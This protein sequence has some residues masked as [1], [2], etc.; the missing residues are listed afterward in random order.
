MLFEYVYKQQ[1]V[2]KNMFSQKYKDGVVNDLFE[3]MDQLDRI[4]FQN[5]LIQQN[6]RKNNVKIKAASFMIINFISF[7]FLSYF[8]TKFQ[9]LLSLGLYSNIHRQSALVF[10]FMFLVSGFLFVLI[11]I[12]DMIKSD[13]TKK[14]N[15]EQLDFILAK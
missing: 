12:D 11:F 9:H 4:E 10:G 13:R 5:R 1:M 6:Q 15:D 3:S 7:G 8:S 2:I 14:E